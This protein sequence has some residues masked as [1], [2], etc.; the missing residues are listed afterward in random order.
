MP[1]RTRPSVEFS[2]LV[3]VNTKLQQK[4]SIFFVSNCQDLFVHKF[5]RFQL[6][7]WVSAPIPVVSWSAQEQ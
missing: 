3:V 4:K 2:M 5:S 1:V 7:F 6:S